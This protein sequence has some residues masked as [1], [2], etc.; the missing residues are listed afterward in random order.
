MYKVKAT[1]TDLLAAANDLSPGDLAE[2]HSMQSGRDPKKVLV[3][4]LDETTRAIKYGSLVLAV[5][6]HA[7]G[8][9]WFVTTNVIGMLTKAERIRFYRILKDHYQ[10]LKDIQN[11]QYTNC[12]SIANHAHIRLLESLGATFSKKHLM[13]P[14]GFQF[15]Q[16]WL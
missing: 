3:D 12:V 6:G 7:N 9:I 1:A 5:G 11:F 8:I 2:F 14:A 16:F 4:A 15:K 10:S 13:S